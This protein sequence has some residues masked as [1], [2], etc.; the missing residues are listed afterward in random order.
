MRTRPTPCNRTGRGRGNRP[1]T[2]SASARAL[3]DL[4]KHGLA[5]NGGQIPG[6][7]TLRNLTPPGS[8]AATR[9][10][11]RPVEEMGN[12]ARAAGRT[13]ASPP[14]TVNEA[15]LA[16]LRPKPDLSPLAGEPA[17]VP[18]AA[19]TA[20]D[21]PAGLDT[22]ASYATEVT[23]PATGTRWRPRQGRRPGGHR[24]HRARG[25][26]P[27]QSVEIDNGVRVRPGPRREDRQAHAVRPAQGEERRRP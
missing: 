8:K 5:E 20:V 7:D 18:A 6:G 15:L 2:R 16:L 27:L 1:E 19:Q 11:G 3:S 9:E 10:L 4:R 17:D 24:H 14:M 22:I 25:Q 13:G 12:P 26:V 21:T 23:L